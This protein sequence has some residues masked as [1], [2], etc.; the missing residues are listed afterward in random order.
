[1]GKRGER[2]DNAPELG[3]NSVEFEQDFFIGHNFKTAFSPG[4]VYADDKSCE[5]R[6]YWDT[7]S[8]ISS[9]SYSTAKKLDVDVTPNEKEKISTCNGDIE[10]KTCQA[11]FVVNSPCGDFSFKVINATLAV[12]VTKEDAPCVLLLG[13]DYIS[14]GIFMT[15]RIRK[16]CLKLKFTSPLCI[17]ESL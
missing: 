11:D 7:G 9:I 14:K 13:M 6:V 10:S 2:F 17:I 16:R 8:S 3:K 4:I 12:H 5:V 15:S 1:M